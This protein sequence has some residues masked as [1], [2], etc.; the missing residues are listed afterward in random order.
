VK[1]QQKRLKKG[2]HG[3]KFPFLLLPNGP[4]GLYVPMDTFTK[5]RV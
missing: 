5:K 1:T 4:Q 2:K 3:A